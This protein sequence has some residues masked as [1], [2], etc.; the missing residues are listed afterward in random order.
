M[1]S[2]HKLNDYNTLSDKKAS[3]SYIRPESCS[4]PSLKTRNYVNPKK[5]RLS[6]LNKRLSKATKDHNVC[7]IET[8][9]ILDQNY[10]PKGNIY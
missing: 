10:K 2:T 5:S 4:S 9:D 6:R 8:E 1:K 3:T 7:K